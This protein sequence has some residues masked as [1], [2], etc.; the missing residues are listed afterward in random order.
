[1]SSR[2]PHGDVFPNIYFLLALGL[3]YG[4]MVWHSGRP[5]FLWLFVHLAVF[6]AATVIPFSIPPYLE[7]MGGMAYAILP[8]VVLFN[9]IAAALAAR[10]AKPLLKQG[11]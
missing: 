9:S 2:G 7:E 8:G 11:S 1:M 10:V 3:F 6:L 5:S 4:V